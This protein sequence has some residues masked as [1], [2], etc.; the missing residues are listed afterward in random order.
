ML[1]AP[2]WVAGT[3]KVEVQAPVW[4]A[5]V[6]EPIAVLSKV[7]WILVSLDANPDPVTVTAVPAGP[8]FLLKAKLG[9]MLKLWAGTVSV[10][11]PTEV[12]E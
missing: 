7:N 3:V 2:P 10:V 1:W 5:V 9:S 6:G 4:L 12:I 8:L 11:V